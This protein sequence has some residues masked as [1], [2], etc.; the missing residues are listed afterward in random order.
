MPGFTSLSAVGSSA[1]CTQ[2]QALGGR[3]SPS[4]QPQALEA[5]SSPSSDSDQD[6]TPGLGKQHEEAARTCGG[7]AP[8]LLLEALAQDASAVAMQHGL[9]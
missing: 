6:L 2:T 9:L 4:G 7:T 3:Q 1:P 8:D 5:S